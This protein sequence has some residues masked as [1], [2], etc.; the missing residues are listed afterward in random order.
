MR[1][2]TLTQRKVDA[3]DELGSYVNVTTSLE[4]KKDERRYLRSCGP[5]PNPKEQA[6]ETT[7]LTGKVPEIDND[8]RPIIRSVGR[9]EP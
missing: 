4:Y 2:G 7:G 5:E 9:K 6:P 3:F 8:H 1:Q